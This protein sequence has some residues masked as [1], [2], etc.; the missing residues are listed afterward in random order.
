VG[1]VLAQE[2]SREEER[3]IDKIEDRLT[4]NRKLSCC[5]D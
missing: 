3:G 1:H 4:V 2:E 5:V